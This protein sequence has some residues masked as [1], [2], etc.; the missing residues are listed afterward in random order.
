[1]QEIRSNLVLALVE[2]GACNP[3]GLLFS[4]MTRA[5]RVQKERPHTSGTQFREGMHPSSVLWCVPA[6]RVAILALK[7]M[8]KL[9]RGGREPDS[10]DMFTNGGASLETRVFKL[11]PTLRVQKSA[12]EKA[13]M[14]RECSPV[15]SCGG[16]CGFLVSAL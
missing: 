2:P 9:T 12:L 15:L 1:M 11:I 6:W 8:S 4:L 13:K 7:A 10:A 3:G 16:P 5:A 14:K